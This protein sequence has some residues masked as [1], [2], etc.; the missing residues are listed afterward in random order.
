MVE[1]YVLVNWRPPFLPWG[2]L[3]VEIGW[4]A[5]VPTSGLTVVAMERERLVS[6]V[7]DGANSKP[8]VR[9]LWCDCPF[10]HIFGAYVDRMGFYVSGTWFFNLNGVV[11]WTATPEDI[12]LAD[13]GRINVVSF[14]WLFN[15][16][17]L[18]LCDQWGKPPPLGMGIYSREA[19]RAERR[20][21]NQLACVTWNQV[22]VGLEE[23]YVW[24][25]IWKV[26]MTDGI[27]SRS[28]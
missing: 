11:K 24:Q 18:G 13:G 14:G 15:D 23:E 1:G 2:S 10:G 20:R 21:L 6:F 7:L 19:V 5:T 26:I 8:A 22:V 27:F 12:G 3:Y 4:S 25:L 28:L 16:A 9:R 17:D